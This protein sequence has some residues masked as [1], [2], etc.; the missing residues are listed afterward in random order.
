M[1]LFIKI[2]IRE[3]YADA[4]VLFF[5]FTPFLAAACMTLL[6]IGA[7]A[8]IPLAAVLDNDDDCQREILTLGERDKP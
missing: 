6:A 8:L 2:G 1:I 3:S 5:Q 4:E 7:A